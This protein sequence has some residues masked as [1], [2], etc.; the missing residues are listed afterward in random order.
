[1]DW[2]FG[3]C[4]VTAQ[5]GALDWAKKFEAAN[6]P[7]FELLYRDV[8]YGVETK[9]VLDSTSAADYRD[10]LQ[11]ELDEIRNSEMWQAGA[12]V[13]GLRPENWGKK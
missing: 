10:T 12:A 8:Q 11:K 13:R 6:R 2:M 3:A 4:S 5:R 1:M 9:R 7:L